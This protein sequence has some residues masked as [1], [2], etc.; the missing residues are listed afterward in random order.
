MR[1]SGKAERD[2]L[3]RLAVGADAPGDLAGIGPR[4]AVFIYNAAR[5]RL[6][7]VF[8]GKRGRAAAPAPSG[9]AF[10]YEVRPC[11]PAYEPGQPVGGPAGKAW[12]QRAIWLTAER[13]FATVQSTQGTR[14]SG[15][16]GT[17]VADCA[18]LAC[19][20]RAL[21]AARAARAAQGGPGAER[22]V[23]ARG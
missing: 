18:C 4:T 23:A 8:A 12:R 2:A 11:G 10:A 6:N 17:H 7:G 5:G 22:A 21:T 9:A 15:R 16:P 3:L 14:G 13:P 19:A 1:G 20:S